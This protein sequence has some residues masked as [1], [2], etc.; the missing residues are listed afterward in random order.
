MEIVRCE[1]C[2]LKRAVIIGDRFVYRCPF[3]TCDVDLDGYCHRGRRA[4]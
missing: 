4:E 2:C 1:E 3:S